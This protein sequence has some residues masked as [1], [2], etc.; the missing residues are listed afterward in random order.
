MKSNTIFI[1]FSFFLGILSFF[2]V[3]FEALDSYRYYFYAKS[4]D[5]FSSI[6]EFISFYFIWKFDFVYYL[7]Q[8]LVILLGLP[9]QVVTGI[10]VTCL[11]FFSFKLLKKVEEKYDIE[12]SHYQ[13]IMLRVFVLT[14]V[15]LITVWSISR[16]V[17]GVVFVTLGVYY[18][19]S[20]KYFGALFFFTLAVFTH[21]GLFLF[22]LLFFVGYL[23]PVLSL[24]GIKKY[25]LLLSPLILFFA[26]KFV[27]LLLSNAGKLFVFNA[28]YDYQQYL[29]VDEYVNVFSYAADALGWGDKAL[30]LTTT[31]LLVFFLYNIKSNNRV[32]S[33]IFILTLWLIISLGF[34]QMYTQRTLLI[35]LPFQ[36]IP[37]LF[38]LRENKNRLKLKIFLLLFVFSILAFIWNIYSYRAFLMFDFP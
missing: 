27:S 15:S 24:P 30:I 28:E 19:L 29:E 20:K 8:Y 17:T 18:I 3:P 26:P 6:S 10:F 16:N 22:L 11:Y 35:L 36:G 5:T 37:A 38:F 7:L 4:F 21:V 34:S 14:S 12:V 31:C 25:S 2:F 9:C 23:F 33:G 1:L 32:L 13:G